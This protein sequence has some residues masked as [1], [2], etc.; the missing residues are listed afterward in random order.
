MVGVHAAFTCTDDTLAAAAALAAEL[1]VGVHIHVAEGP[2]D[3][4]AAQRLA[5]IAR[6]DWLLVHCVLLDRE[7]PGTIAHNPRSN[8]NNGVGYARPTAWPNR[9][10]S[11]RTASAPTCWRSSGSPTS[12]IAPTTCEATPETAWSWLTNGYRLVP[13]AADDL[14]TWTYDH[15]DSPWHVAYTPGMRALEVVTGDGELLVSRRATDAGRP[16]RDPRPRHRAGRTPLRPALTP[17]QD[18]PMARSDYPV[19]LYLQDAHDIREGLG[20]VREAEAKGFTAV[21]QAD[22]RLVRDAVVPMAA[23]AA[24]TDR[25]RIGSGVIDIWTRNPARLAST[26]STLDDLAPGRIICG[27]GAWWDPLAARVGIDRAK[28]LRVMREVVAAV[29]GC[30]RTRPSRSTDIT[31]IS[32]ASS[33]IT[34]TRSAG[35][36]TSRSTSG[37]PGC[38]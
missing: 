30:W 20:Y 9:S 36:R 1:G 31:S 6:D 17:C 15:A 4:G 25:I 16:R 32:T 35:R 19:A 27:L 8:M 5:A 21:W 34:C 12:P 29:R 24:G 10:C 38:R 11:A 7:L 22:S 2:E 18:D 37:R 28:P 13:E 14:V 23:F 3:D 33:S 26:F